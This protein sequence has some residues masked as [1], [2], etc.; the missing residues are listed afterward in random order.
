MSR[1][2]AVMM[3][4]YAL[5]R[6][7]GELYASL[8]FVQL[9]C[10]LLYS[11]MTIF[12]DLTTSDDT[13]RYA[14]C[15]PVSRVEKKIAESGW[16][17]RVLTCEEMP[18]ELDPQASRRLLDVVPAPTPGGYGDVPSSLETETPRVLGTGCETC[19]PMFGQCGA[20]GET[21]SCCGEGL[22]CIKK[23][24]FF[25]MTLAKLSFN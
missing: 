10:A 7:T 5:P 4:F 12:C 3:T 13:C 23:N 14:Q 6:T 15:L 21:V 22:Q 19:A 20:K 17:G 1:F 11:G 2:R 9:C 25:G 24:S 18:D 16:D 8:C